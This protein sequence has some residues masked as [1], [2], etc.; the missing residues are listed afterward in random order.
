MLFEPFPVYHDLTVYLYDFI[1]RIRNHKI[2]VQAGIFYTGEQ[3]FYRIEKIHK[4]NQPIIFFRANSPSSE[5]F[6][7]S[8]IS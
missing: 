3:Q 5:E 1:S 6:S 7:F 8:M 4:F 2:Y